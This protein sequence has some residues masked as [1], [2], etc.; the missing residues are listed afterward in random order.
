MSKVNTSFR[1]CVGAVGAALLPTAMGLKFGPRLRGYAATHSQLQ[2]LKLGCRWLHFE[3]VCD[4]TSLGNGSWRSTVHDILLVIA[5][6]DIKDH[7]G[8]PP[9][10]LKL[11]IKQSLQ[12]QRHGLSGYAGSAG[13]LSV[14]G[15][16]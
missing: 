6:P 15:M 2:Q 12:F 4:K 5:L 8:N 11:T 10:H 7:K 14:G 3:T 13:T 16:A 1:A 9:D